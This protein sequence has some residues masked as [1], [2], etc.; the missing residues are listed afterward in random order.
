MARGS[1]GDRSGTIGSPFRH[2]SWTVRGPLGENSAGLGASGGP[3]RDHWG[4]HLVTIRGAFREY[5]GTIQ[6]VWGPSGT[7]RDHSGPIGGATQD[8]SGSIP[9]SG[10]IRGTIRRSFGD[11]WGTVW[12]SPF[13]PITL[14]WGHWWDHLGIIR[15]PSLGDHSGTI[16]GPFETIP[17]P[18]EGSFNPFAD[19]WS[20]IQDHAGI[21]RGA[22]G[23]R[24][25][26]I[27]GLLGDHLWI[28]WAVEGP[29]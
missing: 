28:T 20:T 6:T 26:I 21:I 8:H 15:G 19:Q 4:N 1:L 10:T 7:I 29:S 17:G 14:F 27:R 9:S 3:F 18:F 23:D 16:R 5:V 12:K 2:H 22:F 11:H 24:S 13:A 25:G